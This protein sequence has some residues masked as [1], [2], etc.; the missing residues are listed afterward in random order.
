MPVS[1]VLTG[2]KHGPE[3]D[4]LNFL[5]SYGFSKKNIHQRRS[6]YYTRLWLEHVASND[7][8]PVKFCTHSVIELQTCTCCFNSDSA[9]VLKEKVKFKFELPIKH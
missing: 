1:R 2:K 5:H 3:K 8:V 7:A 6:V 9:A 4:L